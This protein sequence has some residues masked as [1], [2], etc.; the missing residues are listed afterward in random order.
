MKK[1]KAVTALFSMLCTTV[2]LCAFVTFRGDF[3]QPYENV[4]N[5]KTPEN[6]EKGGPLWTHSFSDG[7]LT[8]NS[9]PIP[10]EDH[11][12][13]VSKKSLYELDQKGN[14][15]K[16]LSLS[17]YADS[18]CNMLLEKDRLYIPLH[19]GMVTCVDLNAWSVL[20]NSESFGGQSLSTLYF[21]HGY[22]YGGATTV[23]SSYT[24]GTFYCLDTDTGKTAWTYNDAENPGGYYW[25]GA[26][27]CQDRLY[28]TGDNG[29][30]V[31][32]DLT[33]DKVYET[34]KLSPYPIRAGLT[35]DKENSELYTV[36]NHG[37]LYKIQISDTGIRQVKFCQLPFESYI[38]CTSTPTLY[39]GRLYTGCLA[40]GYGALDVVN[41]DT[42]T[43]I[44]RAKGE[45]S[46]EIKSSPLITTAYA[47][48]ENNEKVILYFSYNAPPGGISYLEDSKGQTFGVIKPLFI[49]D[50]AKQF[51]LS[52][53]TA[54]KEGVL[55]YS[56]DSGT[57]FAVGAPQKA[58]VSP[59][60]T[61]DT[62]SKTPSP[63]GTTSPAP[64]N[65]QTVKAGQS[66][67]NN[68]NTQ[69]AVK[70][71]KPWK[72]KVSRKKKKV[73]LQFSRSKQTRTFIY[74]KKGKSKWK[75]MGSTAK[76]RYEFKK[77]H[78]KKWYVRLRCGKKTGK[79]WHYS[80]YSKTYKVK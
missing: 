30:L 7:T 31:G 1:I 43:W 13:V 21:Y 20:W 6:S 50:K 47:L 40:D 42:M 64:N 11:I 57:L 45:K 9:T 28:F 61:L 51:C 35:C 26:T 49:P 52:S 75:K 10:W 15:T 23:Y 46:A 60:P 63:A 55:Y 33:T 66:A 19:D 72:I 65:S 12:L 48:A 3:D 29:T 74:V 68:Q 76:C 39:N 24:D 25:S 4:V 56:N 17:S 73:T 41:S 37:T 58:I 44:Y 38:N 5:Y 22:L 54:S 53:V 67:K 79:K 80:A 32:H 71:K 36:S 78:R 34:V 2:F 62:A 59:T 18:V 77:K 70:I 8:Y 16:T 69:S 14:V 27:V